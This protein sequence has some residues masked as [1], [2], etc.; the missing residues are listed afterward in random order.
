[1][2]KQV[3]HSAIAYQLLTDAQ[4]VT[5]KW[6]HPKPTPSFLLLSLWNEIAFWLV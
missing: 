4:L 3:M 5:K 6:Q 1:M 2:Y